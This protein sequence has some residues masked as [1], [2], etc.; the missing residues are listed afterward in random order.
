MISVWKF[1][2]GLPENDKTCVIDFY[3]TFEFKSALHSKLATVFFDEV[4]RKMANAFLKQATVRYGKESVPP[5]KL[6]SYS[7]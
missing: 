1:G 6:L 4:V 5:K 3:V 7:S 2:P